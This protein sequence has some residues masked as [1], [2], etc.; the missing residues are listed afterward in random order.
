MCE[1]YCALAEC[2]NWQK[3]LTCDDEGW[4][5]IAKVETQCPNCT[6]I[7]F[8]QANTLPPTIVVVGNTSCGDLI[9]WSSTPEEAS[10]ITNI[11]T[12]YSEQQQMEIAVRHHSV[13]VRMK[14]ALDAKEY[15]L[16]NKWYSPLVISNTT[17]QIKEDTYNTPLDHEFHKNVFSFIN[18]LRS[19][20]DMLSQ[21]IAVIALNNYEERKIDFTSIVNTLDKD[22]CLV[23]Q[24]V[25]NC[26]EDKAYKYLNDL[27]NVMQHR[28]IPMIVI[29][30]SYPVEELDTI[31]PKNI[32][33]LELIKLPDNPYKNA[34][35]YTF[36]KNF[37]LLVVS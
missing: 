31:C 20:L 7:L 11:K 32:R 4:Q 25:G 28:R 24:V 10:Y 17:N 35:D 23:Q 37:E 21:E 34:S 13:C 1:K 30:G 6:A 5:R 18:N 22:F 12:K 16:T 19:A 26:L 9:N 33:S 15:I 29:Q 3:I 36:D 2:P 14:S 27:R 8:R